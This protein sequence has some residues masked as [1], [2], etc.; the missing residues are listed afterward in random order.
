LIR[1]S[2]NQN[3]NDHRKKPE[4]LNFNHKTLEIFTHKLENLLSLRA[5]QATM[6]VSGFAHEVRLETK[7]VHFM[8]KK[9]E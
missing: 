1:Y 5:Q 7:K 3:Q 2:R 8:V 9:R 4:R 6:P